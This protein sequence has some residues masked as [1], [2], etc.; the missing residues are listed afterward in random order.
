MGSCLAF[1][2]NC[3]AARN[4]GMLDRGWIFM[5]RLPSIKN[6]DPTIKNF[7]HWWVTVVSDVKCDK[8]KA[9]RDY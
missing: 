4:K 3:H 7:P 6:G 2:P 9:V 5:A 1:S 8:V